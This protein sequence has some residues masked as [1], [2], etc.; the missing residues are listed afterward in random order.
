MFK[1]PLANQVDEL[2]TNKLAVAAL[3]A[4]AITE[5]LGNYTAGTAFGGPAVSMLIAA[6]ITMLI[7]RYIPDRANVPTR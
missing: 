4:P 1:T 7:G 2:P 5:V 3:I 6:G